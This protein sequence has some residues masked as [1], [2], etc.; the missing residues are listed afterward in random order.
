MHEIRNHTAD[1]AIH[2]ESADLNRLMAEAAEALFSIIVARL[3]DV[4][5]AVQV[6][7]R[8]EGNEPEYLLVDWLSELLFTFEKRHLLLREFRVAVDAGGMSA[9]ARG[10]PF[11]RRRHELDHEVKAITYHGLTVQQTAGGWSA[12]FV[13]DV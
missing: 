4:R 11:D 1:L 2:V 3:E 10:E 5:P 9:T 6:D 8:V 13:V 12:D 7:I